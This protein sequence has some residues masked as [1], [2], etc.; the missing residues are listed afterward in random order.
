[1]G[2]RHVVAAAAL[3]VAAVAAPPAGAAPSAGLLAGVEAHLS[4]AGKDRASYLVDVSARVPV[5]PAPGSAGVVTVAIRRCGSFRCEK[6]LTYRAA[7][8]PADLSVSEDLSEGSLVTTLFG[9][10]LSLRW[11]DP[12]SQP[13]AGY[14][15]DPTAYAR[16]YRVTNVQGLLAGIRCLTRE[17]LV[18]REGSVDPAPPPA[19]A[20]ALPRTAPR[21]LK[22]LL[23]GTCQTERG[24]L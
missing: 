5:V 14:D 18:L 15:T 13:L 3:G 6:P 11:T 7:V 4:F 1:M 12:Q 23:G 20:A 17:G 16:V 9:R 22:G 2:L 21:A 8:D 24:G 19:P 10:A